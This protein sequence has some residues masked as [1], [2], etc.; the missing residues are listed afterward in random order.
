MSRL[1]NNIR[2][3]QWSVEKIDGRTGQILEIATARVKTGM[4]IS[5]KTFV[6]TR[7]FVIATGIEIEINTTMVI[8]IDANALKLKRSPFTRSV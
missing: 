2:I 4:M 3:F 1:R 5:V 8:V 7:A 6:T